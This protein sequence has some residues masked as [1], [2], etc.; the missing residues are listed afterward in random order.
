MT[1]IKRHIINPKHISFHKVEPPK[2]S[3]NPQPKTNGR[4][5]GFIHNGRAP[6][7]EQLKAVEIA[8]SSN[9][10]ITPLV[11]N[12]FIDDKSSIEETKRQANIEGLAE[13]LVE[14]ARK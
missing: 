7:P 9:G 14:L 6:M 5:D 10:Y 8:V 4:A 1:H 11:R 12:L 2:A 3:Q 13:S